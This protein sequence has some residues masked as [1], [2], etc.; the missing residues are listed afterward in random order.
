MKIKKQKEPKNTGVAVAH[1]ISENRGSSAPSAHVDNR[2]GSV[3]QRVQIAEI[4]RSPS[5]ILQ[6]KTNNTG[7]PDNLKARIENLSGHAMDDMKVHYNSDKPAQLNAHAYAQGTDIHLA[8][9]QE[10]HLPHE[11]WHVVQQ[12]QGRVQPTRQLKEKVNIN[13]EE[14]L[15]KEADVMGEKALQLKGLSSY[16]TYSNRQSINVWSASSYPIQRLTIDGER[17]RPYGKNGKELWNDVKTEMIRNRLSP[18]G[19]KKEFIR[20]VKEDDSVKTKAAFIGDFIASA[21]EEVARVEYEKKTIKDKKDR[22]KG[23]T[24]PLNLKR[25]SWTKKHKEAVESGEDIR[26]VVRNFNIRKALQAEFDVQIKKGQDAALEHFQSIAS[27]L[28]IESESRTAWE[29]LDQTYKAAY[30]NPGNLFPGPGAINRIIG[31]TADPIEDRGKAMAK[32][33]EGVSAAEIEAVFDWVAIMISEK[34]DQTEGRIIKALGERTIRPE[35]ANTFLEG[36]EEF[37]DNITDYLLDLEENYLDRAREA[38]AGKGPGVLASEIGQELIFIGSNFGFDLPIG[39][40]EEGHI[41]V[42]IHTE[43]LLAD[44]T[45]NNTGALVDTLRQFMRLKSILTKRK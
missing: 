11:A 15:E 8:T 18:F 14:V 38:E 33:D 7:L 5:A 29:L 32:S 10:K 36:M 28:D 27:A 3:V 35:T 1:S 17:I 30:L 20:L 22:K 13:E 43:Q 34:T 23:W 12:K 21:R 16:K 42:L 40:I 2:P 31:L 4:Q 44:Y 45:G 39:Q 9:G 26:H 25:P 24:R 19:A 37:Y 6:K 41:E